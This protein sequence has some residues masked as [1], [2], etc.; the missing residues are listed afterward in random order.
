MID[1][2]TNPKVDEFLDRVHQWKE[3]MTELRRIILETPL[4]EEFKWGAPCY[5]YRQKNIVLIQGFKEY[6]ALLFFKGA[7]LPDPYNLL[8]RQTEH[9]QSARQ[10]R[11]TSVQAVLKTETLLKEY[12]FQSIEI[13]KAGLKVPRQTE[14]SLPPELQQKFAE[15]PALA[16]AFYTL[17]PGRQRAYLL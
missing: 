2:P 11:F 6:C 12:L 9:V 15:I 8:I 13:E 17:T 10:V 1:H 4:Q 16:S 3:E 14:L 5:T 7:L